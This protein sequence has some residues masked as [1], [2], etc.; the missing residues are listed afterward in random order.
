MDELRKKSF[1]E[2]VGGKGENLKGKFKDGLG[3]VT[4][5]SRPKRRWCWTAR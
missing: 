4:G 5:A 2:Q 1:D 3:K